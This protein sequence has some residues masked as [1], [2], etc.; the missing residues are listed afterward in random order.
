MVK[1]TIESDGEKICEL[2]GESAFGFVLKN[3]GDATCVQNYGHGNANKR[4]MATY[5]AEAAVGIINQVYGGDDPLEHTDA[6]CELGTK[7]NEAA[8]KNLAENADLVAGM[9]VKI[10][11]GE[12]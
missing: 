1:V 11:K 9:I 7:V 5:A 2:Q 10:M 6:L 4:K 3:L 12:M 8:K